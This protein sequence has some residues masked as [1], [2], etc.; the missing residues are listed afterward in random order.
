M[1]MQG[2][3]QGRM[4][5]RM[6]ADM[7]K[8]FT[9]LMRLYHNEI[10]GLLQELYETP[11]LCRLADVGMHCGCDYSSFPMFR[12]QPMAE[13]AERYTR[14]LHSMGT[15]LI[16]QHFTGDLKQSAAGLLH[17]IATPVFAHVVDFL[18]GDHVCQEATEEATEEMIGASSGIMEALRKYGIRVEEVSDYHR[19]P[20][21][22]NPS[23]GL[24]ADRLEYTLGNFY[25]R[26]R[27]SLE[28]IRLLYE[29]LSCARKGNRS[30]PLRRNGRRRSSPLARWK[31][32]GCIRRTR[33]VTVCSIWLI[34]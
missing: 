34:Y 24:S 30:W 10:P 31:I 25:C 2:C 9:P 1:S 5:N 19:Y 7:E 3:T 33:T 17:D 32:P 11:P 12:F 18:K 21:A 23:P 6:N 15:A 20:I 26:G 29:S 22:D 13:Q 27:K 28:E 14:D 16:V 4:W 8:R